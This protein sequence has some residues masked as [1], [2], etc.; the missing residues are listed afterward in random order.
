VSNN[1]KSNQSPPMPFPMSFR[2]RVRRPQ[3]SRRFLIP[4]KMFEILPA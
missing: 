1:R 4:K 3:R 2:Q